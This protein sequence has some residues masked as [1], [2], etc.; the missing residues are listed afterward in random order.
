MPT[1]YP[2]TPP[3]ADY[4]HQPNPDA[5]GEWC[6]FET[7]IAEFKL[8]NDPALA[9]LAKI[10][11]AADIAA[12]IDTDPLGPGLLAIGLGGLDVEAD[13]E[14][15]LARATSSSTPSTPGAPSPGHAGNTYTGMTDNTPG[16]PT[17]P[18]PTP[19]EFADL[20]RD[21]LR[22]VGQLM[23]TAAMTAPKSGGQLLAAG[24]PT[25]LETVLV[26]NSATLERL[27]HWMRARGKER[28]EA[29]SFRDGSATPTPPRPS[30][31]CCTPA[32]P[33]PTRPTTTAAPAGMP[34]ARSSCTP[35]SNNA[36]N[37]NGHLQLCLESV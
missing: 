9:R 5:S 25:F 30:T 35:P 11:H 7:L 15:L 31:A 3:G 28:R 27:A 16:Q 20:R 24:A 4:T 1:W 34:P 6:T 29:I 13:D 23:A 36:P 32:W 8:G 17:E 18:A 26:D 10:V 19:L 33:T 2:S 12:D 21:V 22:Q 37:G 14:Q